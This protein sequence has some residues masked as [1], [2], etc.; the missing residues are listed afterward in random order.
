MALWSTRTKRRSRVIPVR[1]LIHRLSRLEY[2]NTI[3]DLLGVD[4]RPADSFP[5][6]AGGGSGFDNTA[7][8]LFVPPILLEKLM[9][10]A[11]EVVA[12]AKPSRFMAAAPG[13][14]R[15]ERGAAR[16]S[17]ATFASRAFRR[18]ATDSEVTRL[19]TFFENAR[20]RGESFEDAV[21]LGCRAVLVSPHFL[22]RIEEEQSGAEPYAIS[23]YELASRLS[24]FLWSSMP[25]EELL[26]LAAEKKLS[27]PADARRRKC[28]E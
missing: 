19:L 21:K 15:D 26:R 25:D 28:A 7:G 9:E 16:E 12:A 24:Y 23:D 10:V 2:N 1:R 27:E 11:G 14:T 17:L 18:P 3:R 13:D 20:E 6:D 22:F 4:T 8:T 5:P